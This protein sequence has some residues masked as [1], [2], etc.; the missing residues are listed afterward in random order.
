MLLEN[1]IGNNDSL[2]RTAMNQINSLKDLV[3]MQEI[4]CLD[5]FTF[6]PLNI[7]MQLQIFAAL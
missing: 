1:K 4:R 6:T 5:T 7:M 2:R 3:T